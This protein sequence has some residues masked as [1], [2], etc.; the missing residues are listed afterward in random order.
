[1]YIHT[2]VHTYIIIYINKHIYICIPVKR[3]NYADSQ[4]QVIK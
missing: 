2:Y 1:M 3:L 4:L